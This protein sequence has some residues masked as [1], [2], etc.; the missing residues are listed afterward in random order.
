VFYAEQ[1]FEEVLNCHR[2]LA[3]RRGRPYVKGCWF[4]SNW[5]VRCLNVHC[6]RSSWVA[7]RWIKLPL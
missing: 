5:I 3:Q 6:N 4:Q 2:T 7:I 1:L